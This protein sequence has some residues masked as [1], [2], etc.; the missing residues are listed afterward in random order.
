MILE[1]EIEALVKTG[2]FANKESLYKEAVRF[3]FQYRPDLRIESAVQLY[4]SEEISLARAAEIA[5]IDMESFKEELKRR[6]I[7]IQVC[8]LDPKNLDK[9]IKALLRQ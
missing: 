7:P 5:N 4:I 8:L 6:N 1:K 2:F 3:F 9:G